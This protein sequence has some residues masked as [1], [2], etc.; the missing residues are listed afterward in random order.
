[1]KMRADIERNADGATDGWNQKGVSWA[2]HIEACPCRVWYENGS[3]YVDGV[4]TAVVDELRMIVPLGTD[5]K[6]SDRVGDVTDRRGRVQFAGPIRISS[7]Q[8]RADH[9]V[10]KL[11]VV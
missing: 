7:V 2:T 10:A 5:V 1:M 4:K 11:E 9:I 3:E 6:A 8:H